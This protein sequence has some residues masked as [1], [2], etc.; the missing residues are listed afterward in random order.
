M[1]VLGDERKTHEDKQGSMADAGT[2]RTEPRVG[3][4]LRAARLELG[5]SLEDVERTTNIHAR[6]LEALERD[7]YGKLP[8]RAWARGFL[9]TYAVR[10][11]LNGEDL[12]Q[13]VFPLRRKPRVVRWA[14]RRWRMLVAVLGVLGASVMFAVAA[15]IVA[16]YN[17]FTSGIGD[18]LDRIV[19][20][21]FLDSGPQRVAVL[22]LTGTVGGDNVLAAKVGEDGAGLL[23]IPGDTV[24]EIPGHGRGTIAET[25]TL[26]GPDLT[27]RTVARLT[28]T[29]V[30][31]YVVIDAQGVRDLVD[32]VGGVT[33][34]VPRPVSGRAAP[35]EPPTTLQKGSQSLGGN[36]ALVYLQGRDLS[37]DVQRAERQQDFLYSLFGQALSPRNLVANPTT[38]TTALAYTETN[39]SSPEAFQLANRLRVMEN[40]GLIVQTAV[41]PSSTSNPNA[42][43]KP[44][45][46]GL[47][48]TVEETIK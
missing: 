35:G 33:V 4:R 36:E 40:S 23:S 18:A 21:F 48:K 38:L 27:R 6:H 28:G 26:G 39:L 13:E 30:S 34:D 19:P 43:N 17:S 3:A 16:P 29:E 45:D 5:L 20:G 46:G 47:R 32:T 24:A 7:D 14:S 2:R 41:V 11:G 12:A 31:Y 9:I 22:G 25:V 44:A 15:V 37:N 8:N 42:G 10:L 1:G